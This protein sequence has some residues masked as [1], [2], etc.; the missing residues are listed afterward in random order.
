MVQ[1]HQFTRHPNEDPNEHLG[2]F[3]RMENTIK[4]NGVNPDIIKL[5]FFPFSLRGVATNWF[6]SMPYG[7]VDNWEELVEAFMDR[8][9]PLALTSKI[10]REIIAFNQ[11]KEESLYTAW[12]RYKKLLNRCPMHDIDQIT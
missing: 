11:G 7:S 4:L 5:Q 8:F 12:E 2:R 3:L 6:E 10:I 1:K 9:F